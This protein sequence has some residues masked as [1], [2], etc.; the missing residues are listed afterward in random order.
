MSWSCTCLAC[1]EVQLKSSGC[2]CP[3]DTQQS[4]WG[5]RASTLWQKS[6]KHPVSSQ[7]SP[8]K[9]CS[10]S[11]QW[12]QLHS[13]FV[14]LSPQSDPPCSF[15]P[16]IS[17]QINF[18][19]PSP[20]LRLCLHKSPSKMWRVIARP[21]ELSW[22][23]PWL[24]MA[25]RTQPRWHS[26]DWT[27]IWLVGLSLPPL[28]AL[29]ITTSGFVFI[30]IHSAQHR[31]QH[32]LSIQQILVK[33]KKKKKGREEGQIWNLEHCQQ[34]SLIRESQLWAVG[35]A[36]GKTKMVASTKVPFP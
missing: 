35:R 34:D 36:L 32:V 16:G 33:K 3:G 23:Y 21:E 1:W 29:E 4:G 31:T 14:S 19:N 24:S 18:R 5:T 22:S 7:R 11:Q 20:C 28:W 10:Y 9:H 25:L 2:W 26:L 8:W 15:G 13:P 30:S 27:E 12:F 17:F 6:Q